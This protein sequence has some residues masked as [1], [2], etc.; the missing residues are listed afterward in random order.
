MAGYPSLQNMPGLSE[1]EVRCEISGLLSSSLPP[2]LSS[3]VT[4]Y[5][6]S[7]LS[8]KQQEMRQAA[9]NTD[10]ASLF[11]PREGGLSVVSEGKTLRTLYRLLLTEL[12]DYISSSLAKVLDSLHSLR[13]TLHSS[14]FPHLKLSAL[15]MVKEFSTTRDWETAPVRCL[16]WH[17]HTTKLA[18]CFNDDTITI[19]SVN[20]ANS[21]QPVL[22]HVGMK[23][24]S[25]MCWR[26]YC[27]SQLAVSCQAGV[28]VWTV[29]PSSLVS[30]PSTSC[31]VRLTQPGHS[32]V[33]SLEWSPC[34]TLLASC[35]PADTRIMV[36]RVDTGQSDSVSRAGGGGVNLLRWS[37][38]RSGLL[39]GSPGL[40][41]R[42][43]DTISWQT[44]TWSVA[45]GG[46]R[47]SAAAWAPDS[48]HLLFSTKE[49]AVLYSLSTRGGTGAALPVMEV[50]KVCLEGGEVG[51]GQVQDIQWDP[52]GHRLALI[53]RDSPLLALLRTKPG[54]ARLGPIGWV[55]GQAGE[56]PVCCQFQQD[57]PDYGALLTVAWSSGRLQHLP[58][59]FNLQEELL[60]TH[61][62]STISPSAGE[63]FSE[64]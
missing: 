56:T 55:R 61:N 28:I 49:E 30:R 57:S 4:S 21:L 52:S 5:P 51:G 20:S 46:G 17:P 41:F 48:S 39:A 15:D 27:S 63:L 60:A 26:P 35:S 38:D 8:S 40:V 11:L 6:A 23:N 43:W 64:Q 58:L 14:I 45:Q 47:V 53:F 18:V 19:I 32:P 33:T 54:Q 50:G 34:G 22:K 37:R 36:W 1:E 44:D 3:L 9:S 7:N 31:Q 12:T 42:V 59:L 24:V 10:P 62:S 2:G 16:A 29:D 13:S 25:S